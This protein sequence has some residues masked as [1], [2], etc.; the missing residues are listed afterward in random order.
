MWGAGVGEPWCMDLK[1][2]SLPPHQ[3]LLIE[4][5]TLRGF[6]LHPLPFRLL[7]ASPFPFPPLLSSLLPFPFSHLLFFLFC[8]LLHSLP[9]PSHFLLSPFLFLS[10]SHFPIPFDIQNELRGTANEWEMFYLLSLGSF[11][12]PPLS[13]PR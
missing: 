6:P 5:M 4:A 10:S 7:L 8:S 2:S 12:S 1:F 9:L 3:T 11:C 13:L